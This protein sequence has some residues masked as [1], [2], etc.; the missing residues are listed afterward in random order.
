MA[1]E[2]F[3]HLAEFG[4]ERL[5]PKR[6]IQRIEASFTD[7]REVMEWKEDLPHGLPHVIESTSLLY[8]LAFTYTFL[9]P[10]EADRAYQTLRYHDKGYVFVN[11]GVL[12]PEEHH[13]GSIYYAWK[14]G[15]DKQVLAAIALHIEDVLPPK[16]PAWVRA[17]RDCDRI[18]RLGYTGANN[19]VFWEGFWDKG[20][21]AK[22]MED[23]AN[24]H[25]LCSVEWPETD[26]LEEEACEHF[27]TK[28]IPF[29]YYKGQD[30]ISRVQDLVEEM[31]RRAGGD[32][33]QDLEP[34]MREVQDMC[35]QKYKNSREIINLLARLHMICWPS[36]QCEQ[37][38]REWCISNL[39]EALPPRPR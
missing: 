39:G 2:R 14:M 15:V 10:I 36:D 38:W 8:H 13:Y 31:L 4:L 25:I 24:R 22:E 23:L 21:G 35:E 11:R 32:T 28:V 3:E 5:I 30:A 19:I 18:T 27:K 9:H 12:K 33:R 34:V 6:I 16:T 26:E 7:F 20:L 17:A 1:R 37:E 29:L